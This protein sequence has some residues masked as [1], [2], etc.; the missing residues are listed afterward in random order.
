MEGAT[1][2]IRCWIGRLRQHPMQW[3]ML[4]FIKCKCINYPYTVT[5]ANTCFMYGIGPN[6]EYRGP[7][8]PIVSTCVK[9]V[10][11]WNT[12]SK[13]CDLVMGCPHCLCPDQDTEV[14][15]SV[16]SP[17]D[18]MVYICSKCTL[19]MKVRIPKGFSYRS[20]PSRLQG[21]VH[22]ICLVVVFIGPADSMEINAWY[23]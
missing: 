10:L 17:S 16:T 5:D 21:P 20:C 6:P 4:D 18:G 13:T 3:Q 15:S 22:P 8:A 7:E 11:E 9:K 14:A 2:T 12:R 1:L 23:V 19:P